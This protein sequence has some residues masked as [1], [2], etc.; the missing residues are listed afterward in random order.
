MERALRIAE[1]SY[2]KAHPNVA[3]ALNTL[4]SIYQSTNRPHEAE[5]LIERAM[6]IDE[7]AY[8]KEHPNIAIALNN[9]ALLYQ[10]TDRLKE[11]EPL[12]R[13]AVL[14]NLKIIRAT[15]QE[16]PA[17]RAVFS[18]YRKTIWELGLS[19]SGAYSKLLSLGPD[20]GWEEAKWRLKL[21]D[22]R[23]IPAP[24]PFDLLARVSTASM[25]VEHDD[26]ANARD[27]LFA[28]IQEMDDAR[29]R[30]STAAGARLSMGRALI[31]LG[32][33]KEAVDALKDALAIYNELPADGV[34]NKRK[35]E[36]AKLL[37]EISR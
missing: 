8:G 2:G 18:I 15:G 26:P 23:R 16:P 6:R 11:S 25:R 4:A 12:S 33:K 13:A 14:I 31:A 1:A 37:E 22:L 30:S 34:P 10:A 5:P 29:I 35:M 17:L 7:A 3:I 19:E 21:A 36:C 9:L 32:Q 20:A 24:D 28:L 27:E